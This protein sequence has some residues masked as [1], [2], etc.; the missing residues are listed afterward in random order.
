MNVL[1]G[2]TDKHT[3]AGPRRYA[4]GRRLGAGVGLGCVAGAGTLPGAAPP[5]FTGAGG[6]GV[7]PGPTPP[8]PPSANAKLGKA[9]TSTR[10]GRSRLGTASA[11][12]SAQKRLPDATKLSVR[13]HAGHQLERAVLVQRLVEVPAL[14]RLHAGRATGPARALGD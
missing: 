9:S 4:R 7:V 3:R 6:G 13:L 11:S 5:L 10:V 2:P 12:R 1:A 14:G 8:F